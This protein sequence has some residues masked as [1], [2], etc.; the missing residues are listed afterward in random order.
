MRFALGILSVF[1]IN[2][3]LGCAPSTEYIPATTAY[4]TI[5][6]TS[7]AEKGFLIT[8]HG[9]EGKYSGIGG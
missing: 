9:Y 1:L 5:D 2:V 6:F 8:P 3:L 4:F 7:F